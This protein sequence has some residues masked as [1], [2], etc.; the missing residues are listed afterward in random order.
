MP[1]LPEIPGLN[2]LGLIFPVLDFSGFGKAV[3][4]TQPQ[5]MRGSS[6][7]G[8]FAS[9]TTAS[10][11]SDSDVNMTNALPSSNSTNSTNTSPPIFPLTSSPTTTAHHTTVSPLTSNPPSPPVSPLTPS[12]T[13][14]QPPSGFDFGHGSKEDE[15]SVLP[16]RDGWGWDLTGKGIGIALGSPTRAGY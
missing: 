5:E 11:L 13:S 12:P 9:T 2:G 8:L 16:R 6:I 14:T 10:S 3:E 4:Q 7:P 1:K 15:G